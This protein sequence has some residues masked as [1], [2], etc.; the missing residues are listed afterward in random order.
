MAN[1]ASSDR[2]SADMKPTDYRGAV[3]RMKGI[4]AKTD[5]QKSI[6]AEIGDIYTKVEGVH[7]VNKTAAKIFHALSKLEP[8]EALLVF[9]DVNGLLDAAGIAEEGADLVDNAQDRVVHMRF[10]EPA[11]SPEPDEGG[12]V[13]D[14]IEEL[15]DDGSQLP[16]EDD[17]VEA[18]E[19][20]LAQQ[21]GRADSAA[22]ERAKKALGGEGDAPFTGDNADLAGD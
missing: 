2:V 4:K 10:R 3:Q 13:E 18:S 9:R 20:E 5:K 19:E 17:F 16:F 14:E 11:T 6:A 22:K 15:A 7:G 12:T 1:A 21:Q 8:E